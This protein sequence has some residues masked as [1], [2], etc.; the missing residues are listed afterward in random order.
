ML[1]L[2]TEE[3]PPA[4]DARLQ[5]LER[6]DSILPQ[7]PPEGTSLP[8][9]APAQGGHVAL[10]TNQTFVEAVTAPAGN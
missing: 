8:T 3:G 5:K 9:R 4:K 7:E 10:V 1:A 6:Q 2:H